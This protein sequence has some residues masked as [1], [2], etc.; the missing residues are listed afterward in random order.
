MKDNPRAGESSGDASDDEQPAPGP[1]DHGGKGGMPT[2]EV[3]PDVA[4]P[5]VAEPPD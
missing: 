4:E 5:D 2:R 1:A 3:A